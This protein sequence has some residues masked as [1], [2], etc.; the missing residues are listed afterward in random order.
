MTRFRLQ[1]VHEFTDR[2][3]KV[4]RYVRRPGH[5]RIR[6]PGAPGTAEFMEVYHA[7]L[8]GAVRLPIGA[9]RSGVGTVSAALADYY[10]HNSFTSLAAGTRSSRRA[11]LE[12]FRAD[13]GDMALSGLRRKN[14]VD[15]LGSKK[16]FAARNWKKAIRGFMAWAVEAERIAENPADGIKLPRLPKTEGFHSWGDAEIEQYESC[17]LIGTRARLAMA[18]MLYTAQRRGDIVRMGPQ[19]VHDG[20]TI[21]VRAQKTSRT[22]GKVLQIPI[23]PSLAEVMAAT[24][25]EHLTFLTT[26][27]GAPFT[28]AGFGNTFREYCDQAGLPQCSAHGLRKAQCRRLAEA[29]CSEHEIAAISGHENLSEIRTYTRAAEQ[30]RMAQA[31]VDRVVK[32]F[33]SIETGTAIGKPE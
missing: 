2:H 15:L 21:T 29:G 26:A 27:A 9:N 17:H 11:I 5:P 10:Q 4:R 32:A 24:P 6:L 7:A 25:T 16:V 30:A 1:Y 31:A 14:L 13:F 20:K 28:A 18:L 12:R 19:H 8:A 22:T 23:H 3:G 33:P